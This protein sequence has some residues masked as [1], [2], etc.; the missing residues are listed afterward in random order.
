MQQIQSK[1]LFLKRHQIGELSELVDIIEELESRK[2]EALKEKSQVYRAR[3][4]CEELFSIAGRMKEL[5]VC[6]NSYQNGDDFFAKEHAMWVQLSDQLQQEGYSYDEVISLKQ[7]YKE[8]YTT[9][10]Q[11][12]K[13][14]FMELKVAKSIIKEL[15]QNEE[16][17]EKLERHK[18]EVSRENEKSKHE[19][20]IEETKQPKR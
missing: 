6:E 4:K 5:K 16:T 11:K 13:A 14:I 10:S 3:S 1:Y 12:E 8:K 18:K 7:Y 2:K 19:N 15:S 20:T 17:R 9:V